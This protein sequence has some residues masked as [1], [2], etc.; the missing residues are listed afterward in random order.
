MI[1]NEMG[2]AR[3]G[4]QFKVYLQP[5]FDLHTEQIVGAGTGLAGI[6]RHGADFSGVCSCF[7]RNGFIMKLDEYIWEEVCCLLRKWKDEGRQVLPI[8][9]NVSV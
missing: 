7:E 9:V 2:N 5:K 6:I 4:G 8:S 3:A 1:V